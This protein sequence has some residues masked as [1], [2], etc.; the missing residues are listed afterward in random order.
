MQHHDDYCD[1]YIYNDF[2]DTLYDQD[3]QTVASLQKPDMHL[4][5]QKQEECTAWFKLLDL[6]DKAA[7]EQW[8]NF[9][10]KE[11]LG[12]DLW[13][14][15][16]TLPPSI[17]KL[18]SVKQLNLYRSNLV[19]LPPE[20]G[21]MQNL[22]VFIP[23]TSYNLHWFPYEITR[24][25]KLVSSTVSTRALYGNYK[26]RSPFP[27]LNDPEDIEAL[28]PQFC[29]V[30]CTKLKRPDIKQAWIS[31]PV[32]TDVL[33]LLVN[34]CSQ[35]CIDNLPQ[36]ASNYISSAHQGGSEIIQPPVED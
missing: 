21:D 14:Q 17:S 8:E 22:E 15:I 25:T 5:T 28:N 18:K 24:C 26:Y 11:S 12:W 16:I 7:D 9:D 4:H 35:K 36:G 32:A 13:S 2:L 33:P 31:L 23:Y 6:I 20:I 3:K 30:C 10:P 27:L 1:L 29:S 19:R 34:A